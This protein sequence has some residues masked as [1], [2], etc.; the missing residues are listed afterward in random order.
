MIYAIRHF[1]HC[2]TTSL[3]DE[4]SNAQAN[5]ENEGHEEKLLEPEYARK[6]PS[7]LDDKMRRLD[8]LLSKRQQMFT[9]DMYNC[10]ELAEQKG[11]HSVLLYVQLGDILLSLQPS[12]LALHIDRL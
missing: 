2:S 3:A 8:Y 6:S 4:F 9:T 7:L 11:E 1:R 10:L 12:S 5:E